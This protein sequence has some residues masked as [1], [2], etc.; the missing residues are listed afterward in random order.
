[1]AERQ[2]AKRR[3]RTAL[4][5][6]ARAQHLRD[7]AGD[8][9]PA[10]G[11]TTSTSARPATRSWSIRPTG[12]RRATGTGSVALRCP[13]CEWNGGGSYSQDIVDRFDE[14]LERGTESVLEDL[15]LLARANMEDQID[16]FVA[17]LARGPDPPRRLLGPGPATKLR[18][19]RSSAR[20]RRRRP[21][22][23]SWRCSASSAERLKRALR[24]LDPPAGAGPDL[25]E[26]ARSPR[27]GRR[28]PRRRR[29][30][31]RAG[32]ARASPGRARGRGS[33]AG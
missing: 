29:R 11:V 24:Q 13:E 25:V 33:A 22:S 10:D 15:D 27:S 8:A 3:G 2:T 9:Q 32:R 1:M 7:A 20:R 14:A 16:R 17:A 31:G 23:S 19:V 21:A 28:P 4:E 6:R 18:G 12:R 5:R 26:D 30:R